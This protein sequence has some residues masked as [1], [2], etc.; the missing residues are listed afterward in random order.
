MRLRLPLALLAVAAGAC[1]SRGSD[2]Q[3]AAG[4]EQVLRA[5]E[6]FQ[7]HRLRDAR[8]H[9]ES[10][11]ANPALAPGDRAVA[12][13]VLATLA[14]RFDHDFAR[15]REHYRRGVALPDRP[16]TAW[17]GLVQLELAA[18]RPAEARRAG[19]QAV[20]ASRT[21][22]D[23]VFAVAMLGTAA[24]EPAMEAARAGRPLAAADSAAL[25]AAL[26]ALKPLVAANPGLL[27]P[28]RVLIT[29]ALLMDDGPAAL[30]AF[31]SYYLT[32]IPQRGSVLG[33]ADRALAR[34]LPAW[35]GP[36]ASP[37]DRLALFRALAQSRLFDEAELVG[38]RPGAEMDTL[39][40]VRTLAAYA[41]FARHV[42]EATDEYYRRTALG[43][44]EPRALRD[45][46][47]AA[48]ARLWPRL[49]PPGD[50]A[51]Y[52]LPAFQ[53]EIERR[54]G[55]Y[56]GL[57]E[58]AGYFDLHYGHAVVARE[59]VIE[60]YGHRATLRFVSLDDMAS[61]GFQ[62]WAW[63]SE[64]AHGGWAS[65]SAI[66]EVRPTRAGAGLQAWARWIE[67][68]VQ[69]LRGD[70]LAEDSA[71]DWAR[72]RGGVTRFLPGLSARLERDGVAQILAP[73][74]ARGLRGEA[75]HRAFVLAWDANAD[76][77]SIFGHEG[78]HAI[79]KRIGRFTP[80]ELE[81][82]A[83]LS[84]VAFAPVPRLAVLGILQPN[85]G[86]P[87]PHGQAN[88]QA[89]R[90]LVAWMQAH[91]GEIRGLDPSLPLLPQ[92]TKLSDDQLRAAFRSLD[93]LAR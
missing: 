35:R 7:Q 42:R 21:I 31:R 76:R 61:N 50:T 73:L 79:D 78:R 57:G 9:A 36:A 27:R 41:A 4:A 58:T 23:S 6:A 89:L 70:R 86:D 75:L 14:W 18:K 12:E 56:L 32:A 3:R 87:T 28:A 60:Q 10:A 22:D 66:Y 63:D 39:A 54:F 46:V 72:A 82:R 30:S 68:R 67:H 59:E 17:A 19:L 38:A 37:A 51:A 20:A 71:A 1:A 84:Q 53:R 80:T 83:K 62:T 25:R 16:A 26:A 29:A 44:R 74:R 33:D 52:S 69:T 13:H 47:N 92:A 49:R 48:A 24:A 45:T 34:V 11:V 2:A 65:E 40:E 43:L 15:G 64:A 91:A 55:A 81:Y 90:G 5:G 93:P 77:S 85:A 8:A 88:E